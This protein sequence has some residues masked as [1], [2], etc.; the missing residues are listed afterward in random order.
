MIK[1]PHPRMWLCRC[2]C[3]TKR[4]VSGANLR[5]GRTTNCG[6]ERRHATGHGHGRRGARSS[7]YSAWCAMHTRCS[8]DYKQAKYYFERGIGICDRWHDY[9]LFLA[10]MGER[11]EGLRLDRIDDAIGFQPDNCRWSSRSVQGRHTRGGSL[12]HVD[13]QDLL[14]P[15]AA[16]LVG[17]SKGTV[18]QDH[19]RGGGTL[20]D[21]FDRVRARKLR[22]RSAI[23]PCGGDPRAAPGGARSSARKREDAPTRR[24]E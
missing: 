3:G 18:Y 19:R 16:A 8:P 24:R 13:G 10:D 12:V 5:A 14:I 23:K 7:T 1:G 21:A 4:K 11:P 6:C 20:Q 17:I 22:D 15:D 2:R 9:S